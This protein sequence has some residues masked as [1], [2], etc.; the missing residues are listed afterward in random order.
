MFFR[1]PSHCPGQ[2]FA[3]PVN[4]GMA[5]IEENLPIMIVAPSGRASEAVPETLETLERRG[6]RLIVLS[7]LD[8]LLERSQS[9][10]PLPQGVDEWISPI[11]GI[12]P[13]QLFAKALAEAKGLDPD[14]P[15]G[16]SKITLTR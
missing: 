8:D 14:A 11:I 3:S 1:G 4:L 5:M 16:L 9:N 13:G 7:D 2:G 12:I 6:A 10:L 15:R